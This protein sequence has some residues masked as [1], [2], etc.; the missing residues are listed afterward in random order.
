MRGDYLMVKSALSTTSFDKARGEQNELEHR[1]AMPKMAES[2]G[3]MMGSTCGKVAGRSAL[4]G[5]NLTVETV[6][7]STIGLHTV[8]TLRLARFAL[9]QPLSSDARQQIPRCA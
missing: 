1:E 5:N 3:A 8:T 6:L 2:M 9:A 4:R 7:R